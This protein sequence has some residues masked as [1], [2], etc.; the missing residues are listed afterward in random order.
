MIK[1]IVWG[2]LCMMNISIFSAK[3]LQQPV[4]PQNVTK[5]V[6]QKIP[7]S[8]ILKTKK[9]KI[10]IDQQPDGKYLYQSWPANGKIT[11]K[12]SM[13]ISGGEL[14]PDGTGGNYYFEF[15]NEGYTYQVW[16]NYLTDSPKKA[17][18]TLTVEDQDGKTIVKQDA[19]VVKN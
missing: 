13:I 4:I 15:G 6:S 1:S 7:K 16:R 14:I 12:P 10:K 5:Q 9:F 18:Y 8:V 17:P 3:D 2:A 11:S 19:V